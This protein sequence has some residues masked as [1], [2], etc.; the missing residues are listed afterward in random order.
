MCNCCGC[1][2]HILRGIVE[3]NLP[4]T[5][6]PSSYIAH[7]DEGEC[8][9]CE[10]CVER[11]QIGAIT[12]DDGVAKVKLESCLGCGICV[13]TCSTEAVTLQKRDSAAE[14]PRNIIDLF[15][16]RAQEKDRLKN[17]NA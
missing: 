11:C 16:R 6:A 15:M 13:S 17:Y 5:A 14:P 9:G 4:K 1:C 3:L 10:A 8:A 7:V 12:A 2:C